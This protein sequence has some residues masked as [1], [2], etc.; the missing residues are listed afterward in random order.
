MGSFFTNIQVHTG[1]RPRP[2]IVEAIT[3]SLRDWSARNGFTERDPDDT[4]LDRRVLIDASGDGAWIA[5]YD[6]LTETQDLTLLAQLANAVSRVTK[7]A[8]VG[9]LVH[10]SDALELRLSRS[11]R[12]VD[13]CTIC[14]DYFDH[15]THRRVPRQG[16]SERWSG[17]LVSGTTPKDLQR[18]WE[19]RRA[20]SEGTL[21]EVASLLG[22]SQDR[23]STG[24]RYVSQTNDGLTHFVR[25]GFTGSRAG[26]QR[27][28]E[29]AVLGLLALMPPARPTPPIH[30]SWRP[31]K[32]QESALLQHEYPPE[33]LTVPA[34][35]V[36]F[37]VFGSD[38]AAAAEA[39][40]EAIER[41]HALFDPAVLFPHGRYHLGLF[42]PA[43]EASRSSTLKTQRLF[44]GRTWRQYR[45]G[46]YTCDKL[47]GSTFLGDIQGPLEFT[48][49]AQGFPT[50]VAGPVLPH[51]SLAVS[52]G[53]LSGAR[54][55]PMVE[56]AVAL[57]DETVRSGGG[58]Q[59]FL[60]RWGWSPGSSLTRTP[61][62]APCGIG[63]KYTMTA[64]WCTRFLRGIADVMWVGDDLLAHLDDL[65]R[66][67]A[68]SRVNRVG[69]M[70]RVEL[71]NGVALEE[72]EQALKVLLASRQDYLSM[73][74]R[75][76]PS[77]STGKVEE[78]SD[79]GNP[80]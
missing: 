80:T 48:F 79:R 14:P 16:R 73:V 50:G 53:V 17:L 31:L 63:N 34:N 39:A 54:V 11:G 77:A 29:Q 64:E 58:T 62:E 7:T 46:L 26:E 72:L 19:A 32:A 71:L 5:V 27:E 43:E 45:Q 1:G 37:L 35:L 18:A 40:G 74:E 51:L 25:L 68:V 47:V 55:K 60:A 44:A 3:K 49:D 42:A 69:R 13:A 4:S 23:V 30:E 9:V 78:A 22:M 33:V 12:I 6:E 24:Y 56:Q 65:S 61:Y 76:D 67:A 59:A 8:A 57:V 36:A 21:A 66:L 38:R 41:W 52:L 10:D 15:A 28:I 70:M 75:F 2:E 20:L